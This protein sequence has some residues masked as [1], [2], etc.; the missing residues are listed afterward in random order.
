MFTILA[1]SIMFGPSL[2][3]APVYNIK[4]LSV[5]YI[6]RALRDGT[7]SIPGK[8]IEGGKYLEVDTPYERIPLFVKEGS[9]IPVGPEIQ[10]TDEKPADPVTL[11]VYTGRDCAFTLYEDEGINYDYEKGECSTIRFSL[12]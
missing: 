11:L 8:Y 4:Q 6:S 5:L 9:I 12:Q 3:V 1:T 7:I 10:F 2:L